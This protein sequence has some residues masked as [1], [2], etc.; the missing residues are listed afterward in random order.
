MF[1]LSL[2][3]ANCNCLFNGDVNAKCALVGFAYVQAAH[4]FLS[5]TPSSYDEHICIHTEGERERGRE[6]KQRKK[7]KEVK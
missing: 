3:E 7:A 4:L 2:S 5:M 6:K 1:S